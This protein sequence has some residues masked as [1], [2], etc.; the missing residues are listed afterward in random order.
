MRVR[1][2]VFSA[3]NSATARSPLVVSRVD[4]RAVQQ[5]IQRIRNPLR[6]LCLRLSLPVARN[7][8]DG[9]KEKELEQCC[10]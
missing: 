4:I 1:E 7:R 3:R 10:A 8:R 5:V 2:V 9:T 6:S